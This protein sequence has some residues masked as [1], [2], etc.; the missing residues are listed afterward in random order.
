MELTMASQE[1]ATPWAV[2]AVAKSSTGDSAT[3]LPGRAYF[4][5]LGLV[6]RKPARGD[7]PST[8][9]KSCSDKMALRQCTSLLSSLTSLLV[10]PAHAYLSTVVLPA[11]QYSATG[12]R[13]AF[14]AGGRMAA[15]TDGDWGGGYRFR[16][17]G[18]ETTNLEFAFS[19]RCVLARPAPAVKMATSNLAVAWTSHGCQEATLGGTLQGRKLF[20]PRGASF[21]SN[22]IMWTLA[23]AVAGLF[24]TEEREISK[25][26]AASTYAELKGCRFLDGRSA[27]KKDVTTR[28]LPG[29][30]ANEGDNF[31]L[32]VS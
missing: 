9:S 20:D 30:T 21:V 14:S 8:L 10:S 3:A 4:S 25:A 13:R 32:A 22:R 15:V 1:D 28:A 6:R 27:A 17:F 26:L 5:H 7:A 12:C 18:V 2:P 16:P 29:W 31:G 11:S 19:K 24:G 23:L